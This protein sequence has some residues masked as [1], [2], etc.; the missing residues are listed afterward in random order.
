LRIGGLA[1]GMD[2]DEIVEKM[3][4]A[5]RMPLDRMEQDRTTLEWKRDGFR[6]INKTLLELKNMMLDMKLSKT[7]QSK[8][9]TSSM[10][11]AVTATA[12]TGAPEGTYQIKVNELATS[13]I[14]QSKKDQG[15]E[16]IN[17]KISEIDSTFDF[18]KAVTLAT[19]DEKEKEMKTHEIK[20]DEDDTIKDVLKKINDQ[21]NNVRA[22]YDEQSNQIIMETNRTGIYNE[23]G[24]SEIVF[25]EEDNSLATLFGMNREKEAT[26]AEFEYNGL[27]IHSKDNSYTL[28]DITFNFN[29]TTNNESATLSVRNDT[30]ATFDK[31]MEFVDK[32]NEVVEAM[33][34]SQREEKHRDYK[35]L[36]EEQK[37]E[38]SEK[39]IELWEEKAKS[40]L[41]RGESTITNGL[42][43]MRNSWYSN[44]KTDG[45]IQ[46]L[47]QIGIKTSE[48]YMDGG[49]LIVDEDKLRAALNDDPEGVQN[50]FSNSAKDESRGLVNRLEDSLT[51]TMD[52]IK[53]RAGNS[54]SASLDNY[55]LGKQ[56]KDLNKRISDFED[57][58]VKVEDRYWSQFTAMEKAIQRMNQQSEYLMSQFGQM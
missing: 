27:T 46:S 23:E 5:E 2:I 22:F 20:I 41:L 17:Q 19:Y 53:S 12:R 43:S 37:K 44:V 52:S 29:A 54:T 33:N 4:T 40:G 32:Y 34:G 28:N 38:M 39:E 35:P 18:S 10:E 14:W 56:M 51:T 16:G 57:R 13:E 58:L 3:M 7:Y 24:T 26:N 42:Y 8:T 1:T 30:E 25:G 21:D 55:T 50:L 36:T 47:T 31:I 15:F 49:K 11:N 45:D 6:D 9:V 48:S